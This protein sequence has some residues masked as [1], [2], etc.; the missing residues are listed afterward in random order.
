VLHQAETGAATGSHCGLSS[1]Y[2]PSTAT[3]LTQSRAHR[4]RCKPK[5]TQKYARH[6]RG[7][8]TSRITQIATQLG[9]SARTHRLQLGPKPHRY[10]THQQSAVTKKGRQ[11]KKKKKRLARYRRRVSACARK[12]PLRLHSSWCSGSIRAWRR[13]SRQVAPA[14]GAWAVASAAAV[15]VGGERHLGDACDAW[16]HAAQ[17]RRVRGE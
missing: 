17:R 12:R 8:R 15:R 6:P 10:A 13:G 16:G 4:R 14:C 5:N 1:L 3:K 7:A 2:R 9:L 11:K